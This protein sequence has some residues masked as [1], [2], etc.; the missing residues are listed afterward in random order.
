MT[1]ILWEQRKDVLEDGSVVWERKKRGK[2]LGDTGG[3]RL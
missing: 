3:L 2:R 1:P